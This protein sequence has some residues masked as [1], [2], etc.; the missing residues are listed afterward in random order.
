VSV[1][2]DFP[3]KLLEAHARRTGH[4]NLKEYMTKKKLEREPKNRK[5][6]VTPNAD[7]ELSASQHGGKR[8]KKKKRKSRARRGLRGRLDNHASTY[9]Q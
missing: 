6:G 9:I 2:N 7:K 1:E 4:R 8:R 5:A 3:R